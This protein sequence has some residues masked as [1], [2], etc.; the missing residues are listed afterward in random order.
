[1]SPLL[2]S[3][4]L[5][6]YT[7]NILRHQGLEVPSCCSGVDVPVRLLAASLGELWRLLRVLPGRAGELPN[8]ESLLHDDLILAPVF[9]PKVGD[10][11]P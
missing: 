9:V 11:V 4:V 10:L 2:S 8:G 1:M 5:A 3:K 6:L 7:P